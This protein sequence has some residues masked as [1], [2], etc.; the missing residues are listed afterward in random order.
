MPMVECDM[1]KGHGYRS[2]SSACTQE[3]WAAWSECPTCS[4]TGKT[5]RRP[6]EDEMDRLIEKIR[7]A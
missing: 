4:G 3:E 6:T 2:G 1:C 7:K 5:Y